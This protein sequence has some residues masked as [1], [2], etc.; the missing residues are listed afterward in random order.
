[1]LTILTFGT[2]LYVRCYFAVFLGFTAH[3]LKTFGEDKKLHKA[4]NEKLTMGNFIVDNLPSHI[5]NVICALIWV[6]ILPYIIKEIKVINGSENL[7][8]IVHIFICFVVAY[9]NSSLVMYAANRTKD[10]IIKVIDVK[11]NIAD[12]KT[13]PTTNNPL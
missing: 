9:F 8:A 3:I 5:Y 6:I 10:K 1:M 4:S 7:A 13:K 11:T 2:A 12:D